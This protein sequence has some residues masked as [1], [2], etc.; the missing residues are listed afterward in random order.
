MLFQGFRLSQVSTRNETSLKPPHPVAICRI[1][2][3]I[4]QISEAPIFPP[5]S[6]LMTSGAMYI[7]VPASELTTAIG[8]APAGRVRAAR[9]RAI[10]L[11]PLAM[12][13]AAPKSTSLRLA[14]SASRMSVRS[15][16][17]CAMHVLSGLISRCSMPFECRYSR[18][19]RICEAYILVT[20]SS[21]MRPVSRAFAK[22]PLEQYSSKIYTLS[23][24]T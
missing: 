19:D 2:Q 3:P 18:P 21:S 23:L 22:L 14:S 5:F 6:F 8:S 13:L 15:D 12:T 9:V 7:G 17:D 16:H 1:T 24:C 20:S 4:D 11:L 10:V